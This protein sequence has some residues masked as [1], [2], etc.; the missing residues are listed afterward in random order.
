MTLRKRIAVA[1]Q[2]LLDRLL[3]TDR[4]ALGEAMHRLG[5]AAD[6]GACDGSASGAGER[7]VAVS[8]S[9]G[10]KRHKR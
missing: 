6:H 10:W 8:D 1:D 4:P 7:A 2:D 3:A 9:Q 5:R